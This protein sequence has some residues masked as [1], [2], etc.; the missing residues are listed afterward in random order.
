MDVCIIMFFMCAYVHVCFCIHRTAVI[1]CML[2]Y[3]LLGTTFQSHE[4][5][6]IPVSPNAAYE[7]INKVNTNIN[8]AYGE[9]CN[10]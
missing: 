7:D 2:F 4:Q 5:Q 10:V 6:H 1:S 9:T 8:L 3:T